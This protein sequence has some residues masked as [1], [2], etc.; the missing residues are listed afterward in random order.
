MYLKPTNLY[1][2]AKR[3]FEE[4]KKLKQKLEYN[5]EKYPPGTIH[6][7][8][9]NKRAQYYLRYDS[10]DKSGEYISKQET[11]KIGKYMQKK[12][13]IKILKLINSEILNLEKFLN[14]DNFVHIHK[15]QNMYSNYSPEIKKYI[16]PYDVSDDDFVREWTAQDYEKKIIG[17]GVPILISDKGDH[18]RSKSELNIA[19][20][21]FKMNIPYKYEC[22]LLLS[23]GRFI[24]PDFTIL[25]VT[26][27]KEVYWE[28][29]GMMDDKEYAKHAVV[30][31]REYEKE[32]IYL[33]ESLIITEETMYN[34]L[35]T[36]EIEDIIEHYLGNSRM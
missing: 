29:R 34:P 25:D 12:Y 8:K 3:R 4:L 20:K 17:K 9:T 14:K 36:N 7:I 10:S 5:I 1:F 22:P 32:G 11:E 19:N 33:G 31:I 15:I 27:R 2:E 13:D 35:G 26:N 6:V 23:D 28:H 21:L 30:R 18:V 24:Y 16:T